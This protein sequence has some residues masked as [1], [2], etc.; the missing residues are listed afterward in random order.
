MKIKAILFDKDGTLLDYH[1]TWTDINLQ[2]AQIASNGDAALARQLLNLA[3]ADPD[4]GRA[5]A[6]GL[7]AAGNTAEI[8][9]IWLA[10]GVN[11]PRPALIKAIDHIFT[12]AMRRAVPIAGG[13]RLIRALHAKG[14]VMG[15]ASSDSE[16]AIRVF[17]DGAGLAPY[18]QFIAGYDSGFGH[19]PDPA[20]MSAFCREMG[21][22]A[23]ATAMIGDNIQDLQLARAGKAGLAVGVLSG[24]GTQAALAPLADI[25]L[26]DIT[27]LEQ[28]L[29]EPA[30]KAPA[31][32]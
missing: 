26:P 16:A 13:D 2:A 15:V 23:Q 22:E 10:N 14:Y 5:Q 9:D 18:F 7:F 24:T 32:S 3:D 25:I 31:L 12:D 28:A 29:S 30:A 19:K 6:G 4:T 20:V 21:T 17:L 11:L 1:A 8:V 27:H